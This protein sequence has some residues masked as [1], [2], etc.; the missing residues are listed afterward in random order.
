MRV[1]EVKPGMK[2]YGET[3]F[4]G[5]KLE[6][7]DVEVLSV[8]HNFNPK[9]DVVL[10]RCF[11]DTLQHTGAIAGMSGSPIY[12]VDDEGKPRMVGAF[13]YGWALTKDPIAGVQPIEYMLDIPVRTPTSQPAGGFPDAPTLTAPPSQGKRVWSIDEAVLLP[14]MTAPPRHYPLAALGSLRPNP[15]LLTTSGGD[16][17]LQPLSTPLM[18][19]GLT[20][21]IVSE[22]APLMNAYGMVPL[23][24]GGGTGS[25]AA[26]KA[27]DDKLVPGG[28]LAVPLLVGDVDMTAIGT[29]TEVIGDRVFGFGHPF[30]NE[31]PVS[32]PMG[33]GSIAS[34]IPNLATSFK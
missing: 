4:T 17:T 15:Q 31:G 26:G 34:V 10:I 2:G 5:T 12:L 22:F 18:T 7:F 21:R 23:Q 28:V 29:V 8:L 30:Q 6:R 13:A 1:A 16:A 20:P 3:V 11:G 19:A 9:H 32:L 25:R 33:A 24:A 14:G 27:S